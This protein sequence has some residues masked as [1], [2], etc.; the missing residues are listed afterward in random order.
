MTKR[1][2]TNK[3][4]IAIGIVLLIFAGLAAYV[5]SS[6]T[7]ARWLGNTV[8]TDTVDV[9]TTLPSQNYDDL[10]SQNRKEPKHDPKILASLDRIGYT[11]RD[12]SN[13]DLVVASEATVQEVCGW[14]E[15]GGCLYGDISETSYDLEYYYE[16]YVIDTLTDEEFDLFVAHEYLHYV[17]F[18][19]EL[20]RNRELVDALYELYWTDPWIQE[21]IVA[22]YTQ[23]KN[24]IATEIFSYGC[25]ELDSETLGSFLSNECNR[26]IN[27]AALPVL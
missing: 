20:E 9:T 21:R 25:T 26:Y 5:V 23:D 4:A 19:E 2:H 17:W 18:T 12:L 13:L 10:E 22:H 24:D 3:V 1:N 11:Q 8:A 15:A 16:L 14:E 6:G 27:T 7:L